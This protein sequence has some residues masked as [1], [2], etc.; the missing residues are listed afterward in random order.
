MDNPAIA[1]PEMEPAE[2]AACIR[3]VDPTLQIEDPS[4]RRLFDSIL[5]RPLSQVRGSHVRFIRALVKR[6]GR[7]FRNSDHPI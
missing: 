2:I 7:K 6:G 4:D 5:T 3:G 1:L